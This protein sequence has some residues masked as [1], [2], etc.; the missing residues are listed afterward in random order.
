VADLRLGRMGTGG[1]IGR[2]IPSQD[3]YS[4]GAG[5]GAVAYV[6]SWQA[7]GSAIPAPMLL[8]PVRAGLAGGGGGSIG[9]AKRTRGD[10][11]FRGP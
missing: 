6:T 7:P 1:L 11:E 8:S 5:P 10:E 3:A 9:S 2:P 4:N